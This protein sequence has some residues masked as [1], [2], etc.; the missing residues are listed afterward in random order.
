MQTLGI[1]P[2]RGLPPREKMQCERRKAPYL[3]KPH[4]SLYPKSSGLELSTE[5][6][7]TAEES[8][9]TSAECLSR[10]GPRRPHDLPHQ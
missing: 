3:E 4:V 1:P 5:G 8:V 2:T 7:T 10:H 6:P 9:T